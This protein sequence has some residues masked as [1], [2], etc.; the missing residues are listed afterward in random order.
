M[1]GKGFPWWG[2]V[3]VCAG[4]AAGALDLNWFGG[5]GWSAISG[6]ASNVIEFVDDSPSQPTRPTLPVED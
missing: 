4:V 5:L 6:V 3:A 2:W 1:N